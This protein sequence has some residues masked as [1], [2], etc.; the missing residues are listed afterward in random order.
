M[1]V[2]NNHFGDSKLRLF[3]RGGKYS[4]RALL[5]PVS[6]MVRASSPQWR[7]GVAALATGIGSMAGAAGFRKEH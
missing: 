3:L 6:R 7:Y 1:F 5:R 4:A 2:T